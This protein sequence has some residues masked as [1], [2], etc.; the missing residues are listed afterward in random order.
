L[1]IAGP[2]LMGVSP[3][4]WLRF[5]QFNALGAMLWACLIGGVG[6]LFGEAAQIM[7]GELKYLEIWL[8]LALAAIGLGAWLIRRAK[9]P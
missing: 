7:L 8:I 4:P 2:V 1:R 3:L 5:A 9:K 6:W